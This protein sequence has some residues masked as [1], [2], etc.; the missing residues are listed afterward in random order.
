M[1]SER[2]TPVHLVTAAALL[3]AFAL[4][5][6]AQTITG[7]PGT[8]SPTHET[9]PHDAGDVVVVGDM[10]LDA[11]GLVRS[12]SGATAFDYYFSDPWPGGVVPLVF[13]ADISSSERGL[14]FNA[15]RAW[16][17]GT[18]VR[19]VESDPASQHV[20][21]TR[22]GTT[23][24]AHVG[25]RRGGQSSRMTL[26]LARCWTPRTLQH[27]LG[28]VLGLMH[29][30]QR[31]DRD[32]YVAVNAEALTPD[33]AADP[34]A[35][36]AIIGSSKDL[37]PYDFG[38]VMHYY[39]TSGSTSASYRVLEA[40]P[41]FFG[42]RLGG[43]VVS[44]LDGRAVAA[45]YGAGYWAAGSGRPAPP[46]PFRV[47]THE[48]L[49][50]MRAI[51]IFYR[52]SDGLAR[53][54]GL[55]IG[56]RPDFLG[57]AAWFFDVYLGARFAGYDEADARFTVAAQITQTDEWRMKHPGQPGALP[58]PDGRVLAFDRAELL[59][60]MQR[61]DAYYAAP[62]GLQRPD[63]LS[64]DGRPDFLGIAAW[65]VEYYL[66]A[67]LQGASADAAWQVVVDAIRASDEWRSK[68]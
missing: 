15:C 51:D 7:A 14:V 54:D 37:T 55:S 36:F 29:E 6:P 40:R 13:D 68:H 3:C 62:E 59:M 23:C 1:S 20:R 52:S 41:M 9:Q 30:H 35:S 65:V 63:G 21:V 39:E 67:R 44:T 61:L 8:I 18:G 26:S 66:G 45:L 56:G 4:P 50:A 64:I 16:S 48:A 42:V 5:A 24:A 49:T 28:H 57:L 38:S 53:R 11:Q 31:A 10:L 22:E 34:E 32:A 19:C 46:A 58:L 27:E 25:R 17:A 43:D 33:L 2:L 60:V 12:T 47:T